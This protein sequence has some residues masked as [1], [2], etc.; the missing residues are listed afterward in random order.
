MD[1]VLI[2][3]GPFSLHWYGVLIVG[4]AVVAALLSSRYAYKADQLPDHIWNLLA[5]SLLFGIIG[6][7]L[8]HVI[9]SPADGLGW[10]YYRQNPGDIFNFWDGGFRGLGIY[11]G[12]VGGAFGIL[13]YCR[14]QKLD[15]IQYLDFIAPNILLAQAI[16]R[17]GNYINQELY[18]P[19]T[20]LP[21]AFTI[22]PLFPCQIPFGL[23]DT[24]QFCGSRLMTEETTTWYA[25]NG[26]HPT[27]FYEAGWNVLMFGV[28]T[29]IIWQWG[30]RLRRG[31][32][33]LL[34]LLSYSVG[35]LWIEAFRP[36]AWVLGGL[37]TIQW[38]A[39]A[40]IV[41]SAALLLLRHMGW[42]DQRDPSDSLILMSKYSKEAARPVENI[43]AFRAK[44]VD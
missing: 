16:G 37:P 35:R 4:G 21:W 12:L 30:D 38:I 39:A 13:L 24:I 19:P 32:S 41:V 20:D 22:N 25:S 7:R 27:F 26:F 9:S 8:Y 2:E 29:W 15:V 28:L 23:P 36:D 14:W 3:V 31:D 17:L 42:S 1:P 10:S 40:T 5:V 18:G 11:G 33:I 44:P 34:Y 43:D 6:A